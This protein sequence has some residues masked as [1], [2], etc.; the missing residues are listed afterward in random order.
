MFILFTWVYIPYSNPY[1]TQYS[2]LYKASTNNALH[3]SYIC[4][5]SNREEIT[6]KEC[7]KTYLNQILNSSTILRH[8]YTA[9]II[10]KKYSNIFLN[11]YCVTFIRNSELFGA[12][13]HL[14]TLT[15]QNKGIRFYRRSRPDYEFWQLLNNK[16]KNMM[17]SSRVKIVIWIRN[18]VCSVRVLA[19]LKDVLRDFKR[20]DPLN[21][22]WNSILGYMFQLNYSTALLVFFSW[23]KIWSHLSVYKLWL[24]INSCK[25]NPVRRVSWLF[26]LLLVSTGKGMLTQS[27]RISEFSSILHL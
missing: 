4:N 24:I 8:S 12:G 10:R 26:S 15:T 9:V 25:S 22:R 16:T 1:K 23:L 13:I 21:K 11:I 5:F 2:V 3:D 14:S 17:F 19:K 18:I 6:L 20:H 7:K 27:P